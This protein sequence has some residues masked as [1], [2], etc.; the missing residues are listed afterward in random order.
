MTTTPLY[1]SYEGQIQTITVRH[2][3][4]LSHATV[5]AAVGPFEAEGTIRLNLSNTQGANVYMGLPP[6]DAARLANAL[7]DALSEVRKEEMRLK[8]EREAAQEDA[9]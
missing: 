5:Q 2:A 1:P 3:G 9:A 7:L 4:M 6:Q 8:Q